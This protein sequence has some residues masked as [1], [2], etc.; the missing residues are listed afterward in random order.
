VVGNPY[1]S[2][3]DWGSLAAADRPGLDAAL[4]VWQGTGA[5]TGR[6]R[7]LANGI[8]ASPVLALGQGFLVH[9][10]TPGQ[11]GQLTLRDAHRLATPTAPPVL[12]T[13]AD[14]RPQLQLRLAGAGTADTTYVYFEAGATA[15]VTPAHDALKLVN[16]GN[17]SIA[18]LA[19]DTALAINGRPLLTATTLVPVAVTVPQAGAYSLQAAGLTNFPAG[20]TM[21]LRDALLGTRTPLAAGTSYAINLAD[22]SAPGRFVVEFTPAVVTAATPAAL[23]AQVLVYPNPAHAHL[24]VQLPMGIGPATLTL[25][26]ALGQLVLSQAVAGGQATVETGGLAAGVYSLRMQTAAATITK[27]VTLE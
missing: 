23:A 9:T 5:T 1:P 15:G 13:T 17:P 6:Y 11:A 2:P 10:T 16:P 7:V 14:L 22:T 27:R 26:N 8:G 4:Y 19:G 12:R 25:L 21:Y 3:L 18:T 20:T 24:H